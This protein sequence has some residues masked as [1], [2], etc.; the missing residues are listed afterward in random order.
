MGNATAFLTIMKD[1]FSILRVK[2]IR[3]YMFG[4]SISLVGDWMQTTAQAWLVWELTHKATA[5]GIV[6]L[7]SQAPYFIL[8][9]W[10]GSVADAYNRK[11][12][13]MITQISAC[14]FRFALLF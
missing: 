7:L 6:V 5:L 1:S 14:S 2:N 9:P 11:Y 4:Q 8:G 3:I 12:I 10:V 13:L